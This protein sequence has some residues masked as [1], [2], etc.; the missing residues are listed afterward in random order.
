MIELIGLADVF[1]SVWLNR[2]PVQLIITRQDQPSIV[3]EMLPSFSEMPSFLILQYTSSVLAIRTLEQSLRF[4]HSKEENITFTRRQDR[5]FPSYVKSSSLND[6]FIFYTNIL[7]FEFENVSFN[8]SRDFERGTRRHMPYGPDA[9]RIADHITLKAVDGV[10]ATCWRTDRDIRS[11]D[12]FAIDFLS[13]QSTVIFTIAVGYSPLLQS[14][15]QIKLSFDGVLWTRYGSTNG[16]YMK[17][18]RT[19]ESPINAYLFD[20]SEF[21]IGFSSFR[22]IAFKANK[23]WDMRFEVCEVKAISKETVTNI[24]LD[25]EKMNHPGSHDKPSNSLSQSSLNGSLA[26][27]SV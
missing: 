19:V 24:K 21:D 16:I 23:N 9:R 25:F 10:L 7:P 11:N 4:D 1:F 2:V 14:A 12:F 5:R 26:A 6:D 3:A 13:I 8:I 17:T 27:Q 15:L 22:Y 18:N 20:S